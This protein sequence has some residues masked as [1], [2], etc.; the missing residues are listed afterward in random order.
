MQL[1]KCL[2]AQC[3]ILSVAMVL[4]VP[5]ADL[6]AEIG[7]DGEAM[8]GDEWTGIR[9]GYH[10]QELIDLCL[11]RGYAC[12]PIEVM[13]VSMDASG[14]HWRGHHLDD[15]DLQNR[16]FDA[17]VESRGVIEG[18]YCGRP[19]MVA[20]DHGHIY[21]PKGFDY[22]FEDFRIYNFEPVCAWRVDVIQPARTQS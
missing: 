2:G 4:D 7:H 10:V 22:L 18:D 11:K 15:H 1:Q 8:A 14:R 6:M 9:R 17:L 3:T 21:D 12:T 16:F 20:Y 19:H 13:P 5:A